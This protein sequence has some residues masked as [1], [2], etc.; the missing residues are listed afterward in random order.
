MHSRQR[1]AERARRAAT[2]QSSLLQQE[3]SLRGA[4]KCLAHFRSVKS[5]SRVDEH[6]STQ[7]KL[8]HQPV[9]LSRPQKGLQHAS[10]LTAGREADTGPKTNPEALM[11]IQKPKVKPDDP[12]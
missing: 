12:H 11:L 9:Q 5:G 10:L 1:V 6:H 3:T 4:W 7:E 8:A 2:L